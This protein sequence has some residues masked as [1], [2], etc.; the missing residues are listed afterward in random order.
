MTWTDRHGRPE[1]V[2]NPR[3]KRGEASYRTVKPVEKAA[4]DTTDPAPAVA[5]TEQAAQ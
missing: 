5:S 4:P 3:I 1:I 2:M